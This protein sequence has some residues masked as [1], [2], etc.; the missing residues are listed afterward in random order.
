M[1][2]ILYKRGKRSGSK[3]KPRGEVQY[4]VKWKGY[5][6]TYNTWEPVDCLAHCMEA[7]QDYEER[8]EARK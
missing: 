4:L 3:L 6:D 5:S 8:L 1:Q 7:V 2:E